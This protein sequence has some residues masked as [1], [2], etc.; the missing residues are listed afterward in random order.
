M[1]LLPGATWSPQML[2]LQNCFR[3]FI[4][5]YYQDLL[6]SGFQ[7]KSNHA[8]EM[9][10]WLY[11]VCFAHSHYLCSPNQRPWGQFSRC[12]EEFDGTSRSFPSLPDSC[13]YSCDHWNTVSLTVTSGVHAKILLR[14]AAASVIPEYSLN[15]AQL[16]VTVMSHSSCDQQ[17]GQVT[18]FSVFASQFSFHWPVSIRSRWH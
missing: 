5:S 11:T 6:S 3:D 15:L 14:Q 10:S 1:P 12:R 9:L 7:T 17:N 4:S 13:N 18:G 8:N 16:W 2:A